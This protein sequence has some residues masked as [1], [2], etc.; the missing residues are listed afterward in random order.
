MKIFKSLLMV[1]LVAFTFTTQA[2][3][4]D[5]I[6][7]NYFENTGGKANWDKVKGLKMLGKANAQGMEIPVELVQMKDGRMYVQIDIQGQKMKQLA[8]DGTNLW[9]MNFM[10]QKAEK[11]DQ[12]ATEN[13]KRSEG[14]SF[15]SPFFN[16][17]DHG[18]SVELLGKETK[19]GTECFKVK[20]TQ[21]PILVDGKEEENSSIYFFDTENYVPIAVDNVVKQGPAK[22]QTMTSTMSDYQEVEGLYFPFTMSQFG[23][24][25]T[26]DSIVVNPDV[27]D[28]D[29]AMPKDAAEAAPKQ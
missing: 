27:S 28:A 9:G 12:E 4:A 1:C 22:G 18:Y 26:F 14:K 19:E 11:Q 10:T 3:T 2:Q 23:A 7:N 17:K 8:F 25:I 16:Y 13:F 21:T 24:P 15:P 5:E 29:F 20:L 6:I